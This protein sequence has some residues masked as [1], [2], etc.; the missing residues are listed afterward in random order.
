M[1]EQE[2]YDSGNFGVTPFWDR[3]LEKGICEL[4][5]MVSWDGVPFVASKPLHH[6]NPTQQSDTPGQGHENEAN[7]KGT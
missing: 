1:T 2:L 7:G 4:R 6:P 3:D 5:T